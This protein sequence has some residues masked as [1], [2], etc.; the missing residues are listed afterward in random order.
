V[1]SQAGRETGHH[2]GVERGYIVK[3]ADILPDI[4]EFLFPVAVPVNQ[5]P[6]A[7]ADGAGGADART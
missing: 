7:M 1:I 5:F 3:F 2:I 6:V 4:E